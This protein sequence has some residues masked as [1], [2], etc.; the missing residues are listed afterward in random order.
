MGNNKKFAASLIML[1][2]AMFLLTACAVDGSG[3]VSSGMAEDN[4]GDGVSFIDSCGR[5][6]M[7]DAE[8]SR[9]IPTGPMAQMVLTAIAPDLLA[10]IASPWE[11]T[12]KIYIDEAYWE[13]PAVYIE[14]G[15]AEMA[16]AF[17]MLGQLLNRQ[18]KAEELAAY[19]Q[20]IYDCSQ[21][22]MQQVGDHK[23]S[24]VYFL[25]D[26]GL[27]VLAKGLYHA[28]LLDMLADN[29]AVVESLFFRG[30]GDKV[31]LEQLRL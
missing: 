26:D 15:L 14:A 5:A 29:R 9:V 20:D 1:L 27:N 21:E 18:Q 16:T 10:G 23:I 8:I 12:E 30:T 28:E 31:A 17:R 11:D 7:V 13:I 4:G 3:G 24:L 6:L 19:C 22:I 2:T 25:G